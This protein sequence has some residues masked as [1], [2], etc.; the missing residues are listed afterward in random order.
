MTRTARKILVASVGVATV[1][2]VSAGT[3][4]S[5]SSSSPAS[6]P[7]LDG[8]TTNDGA[9]TE[10]VVFT[11]PEGNLMA[12]PPQDAQGDVATDA[13]EDVLDLDHV[14]YGPEG[15]LMA[16]P[17]ADAQG[18]VATDAPEDVLDLDHVS[19][20]PEGNLMAPPPADAGDASTDAPKGG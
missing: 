8:A 11:G 16:P 9:P 19:Y 3:A 13:P 20:G 10:D 6:E 12:P 4:C 5:S 18:D 14:S 15:N 2:Y 1:S 17:P 7:T